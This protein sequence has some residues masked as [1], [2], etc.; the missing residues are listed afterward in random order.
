MTNDD[1]KSLL[2]SHAA[3]LRREGGRR[4]VLGHPPAIVG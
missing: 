2:D 4:A 1:L 3:W